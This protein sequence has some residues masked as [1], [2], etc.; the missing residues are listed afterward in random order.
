MGERL[1]YRGE[2]IVVTFDPDICIA[3]GECVRGSRIVFPEGPRTT[4]PD[5]ATP[6]E[7]STIIRRCP[8]GALKY[9]R[10][11]GVD[12]EEPDEGV[13][14]FVQKGGPYHVRGDI[15]ITDH[16]GNVLRKDTRMALCRCGQ[17]N[18][19]PFCD[20]T[21]NTIRFDG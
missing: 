21:H 17:S 19:K 18:N 6:E 11:D 12:N 8:S 2:K 15:T 4:Q 3:A 1:E 20:G 9:D 5:A 13:R 7:I 14:I 16:R 10:L